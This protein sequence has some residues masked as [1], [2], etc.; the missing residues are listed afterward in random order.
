[1][2]ITR[3]HLELKKKKRK[4]FTKCS[5]SSGALSF[6]L[7]PSLWHLHAC[8]QWKVSGKRG[9]P[10][11]AGGGWR[12]WSEW[13]HFPCEFLHLHIC[14]LHE[15]FQEQEDTVSLLLLMKVSGSGY[16]PRWIFSKVGLILGPCEHREGGDGRDRTQAFG[17]A[18][19]PLLSSP[20]DC[21]WL[22]QA[23]K[24]AFSFL[25][26]SQF[27]FLHIMLRSPINL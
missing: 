21:L 1:M 22:L 24:L 7:C 13:M 19:I 26:N 25:E 9:C 18:L 6:A 10:V 16:F 12:I 20:S 23:V 17:V 15:Q 4:V 11:W 2:L 14:N 5:M 8:K 3:K 27:L